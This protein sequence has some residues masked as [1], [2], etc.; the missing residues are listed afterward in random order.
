MQTKD[1]F[2]LF[3]ICTNL[4]TFFFIFIK[5]LIKFY[6]EKKIDYLK[7]SCETYNH[8]EN[9]L[10]LYLNI[11]SE[12]PININKIYLSLN[13]NFISSKRSISG[14]CRGIDYSYTSLDDLF[15]LIRKSIFLEPYV[16]HNC[17]VIFKNDS[18]KDFNK[19]IQELQI[20][21]DL[22]FTI[23]KIKVINLIKNSTSLKKY[24]KEYYIEE[25]NKNNDDIDD[26][27]RGI[28]TDIT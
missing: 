25:L 28:K 13:D 26:V 14:T 20:N 10:V 5:G 7:I 17:L 4:C 19:T 22:L 23:K 27:Y 15:P 18:L 11:V 3:L 9:S 1:S 6:F 8:Y 16:I 24:L 21:F 2:E 12:K